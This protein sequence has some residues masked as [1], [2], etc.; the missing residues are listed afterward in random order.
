[1]YKK[2]TMNNIVSNVS[3]TPFDITAYHN[4]AK[5]PQLS[6]FK[7]HFKIKTA[8]ISNSNNSARQRYY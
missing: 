1:M 6:H 3:S 5:T 7:Q 2:L 4:K 8:N